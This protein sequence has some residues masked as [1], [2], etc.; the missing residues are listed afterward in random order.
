M[1]RSINPTALLAGATL[2]FALTLGWQLAGTTIV[3]AAG[4]ALEQ[5]TSDL[6]KQPQADVDKKSAGCLTCHNPDKKAMH[7]T[8]ERAGC[9]DCHGGNAGVNRDKGLAKDSIQFNDIKRQAHVQPRLSLWKDSAA[10]PAGI[11]FQTIEET[12]DFIRFVNPG[13]LRVADLS[14]GPCHAEEVR[15]VN[16]SMMRHGGMLWGAASYNNGSFPFKNTVFGEFY[17]RGGLPA[18]GFTVPPP[19]ETTTQGTGI[20]PQLAPLYPWQVT[21]P[22]NI[23]RI[24]ERGGRRQLEIGVPDPDEEPGRPKNRLSNR[25]LGTLNRTDPVFI[26]LQKTRL[27]DPT[28]NFIGSND[29]PGDYRSGGCTACHVVYANDRSPVHSQ[30]YAKSGNQGMSQSADEMIPKN[31]PGHPLSHVM[32]K[33]APTSQCM[34][35]HMHPGTNM[36]ATYQGLTWWDN[37]TDGDKMYPE[38]GRKLSD[39]ERV[40]IEKRNPEGSALR[41]L[42]SDPGFLQKT[43]TPEFN[44][45]LKQTQFADFHGHGWLFRAVFK[46]DRKGN[47]IDS[48]GNPVKDSSSGALAEAVGYTDVRPADKRPTT[49]AAREA[50]RAGKPVHL[51]D[52]HLERGMQCVDCHFKQDNHGNG[53]LYGEPRNGIEIACADCHG[54]TRRTAFGFKD[55]R[56]D[57]VMQTSGP[58]APP[59][60]GTNL[61]R[62]NTPFGVPRFEVDQGRLIQRSVTDE[63]L[64]WVVPQVIDSNTP[65]RPGY[66]EKARLA[67]TMQ[68]D[69]KTWGDGT[70]PNLAHADERIA[71][72]TCHSSWITSCFGCHLAQT[73]NQKRQM[74]HN[75][76]TTTRNWTSY[77]FQLLRDDIYMIG[78]DGTAAGARISPVR[79]SS[80]VVVSSQDLNRQWIYYQQQTVSAEGYAGQAFNTH[81]P[82]TVRPTETKR[83]TD[84]HVSSN[85]DNNAVIAQLFTLG[86]NLVNFMGRFVYVGTGEGGI[87]A[88]AVTEM[89]EPQA[90]IG[91][92]LH[93]LA[94]PEEYAAHEKRNRQLTTA[95]HHGSSNALSVQQRGEYLYIADGDGGF[96][97][98]DLAQINQKGFSQKMMTAPVSPIGQDTNVKTRYATAVAAPSTL[99]VDPVRQRLP[100]NEEQPIAPVYGYIYITDREEGL[101][102]ST[103]ATLL[104]GN[105]SNNFLKRA[106]SFNP[107]N[108]L[109][110]AQ[111]LAVAGNYAYILCDRGLVVVNLTDPTKPSIA[112][113]IAAPEINKGTAIS[114]QF[115]YAFITD[116]DGLKVVDVTMPD[117]VRLVTGATQKIADARGLYVARTYAYVAAGAGGLVI[118]DVERP[119]SPKID[120]TFNA[121]GALNDAHD[122]KIAMTNA[123]VYGYVAD[124][125]NGLRVLEMV[126]ANETQGAFGFSPRPAPKLIAT[127][128]THAPAL[129]LSKGL[130]R[131]RAVDESGNQ[132]AVFGRRGGRPFT[133][134]EM[135]RMFLRPERDGTRV[136]WTVNDRVAVPPAAS[137]ARR[138]P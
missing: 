72:A 73:A 93:K 23:L 10:N 111:A 99:A 64:E 86:T 105:P 125:K 58:A 14:C 115:R 100:V 42:W 5:Q 94:Y 113:E 104:D 27:L 85:G 74:L 40:A 45:Q 77:N 61:L 1:S 34:T 102:M 114:V 70:S 57:E 95:V 47:L 53:N 22:G 84:C 98:F 126:S 7:L 16:K 131:D 91:S 55:S 71:C 101:V 48:Q 135:R 132:V 12:A 29:A 25:G 121:G 68:R 66:T 3:R 122:V 117:K 50:E 19:S 134:E 41:G 39:A 32:V 87:D 133:L 130:D 62:L 82:H 69:G 15:N 76:I 92:D 59:G 31:E 24:F 6:Q 17:T 43:G 83:C 136:P 119:E 28:L 109:H 106:G 63:N 33:S 120:Q 21:Q 80:A 127:Y 123:S 2:T 20:L 51:K 67:H 97:V 52:I 44:A 124:G 56:G 37:E 88:V 129:S 4:E 78:K 110:G 13:D 60:G 54:T 79:S 128:K 107:D 137:T 90:V 75:E 103:A 9:T 65:G 96:R 81:V 112:S 36:L 26:G 30:K 89:E 49:V 38:K 18:I 118:V 46:R 8:F 108:R 138:R 35:C 11:W 116:A